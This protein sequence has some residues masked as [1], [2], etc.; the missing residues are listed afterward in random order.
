MQK[1]TSA[2]VLE[3]KNDV[4]ADIFNHLLFAD[5]E[6]LKINPD[7]LED[8]PTESF[9]TDLDGN[10]RNLFR[11]I[12]KKYLSEQQLVL[13]SLGLENEASV[14]RP[15]PI[16]VM[17]YAYTHYKKQ[18]DEYKQNKKSLLKLRKAAQTKAEIDFVENALAEL[19]EFKL[20]P[21]LTLVLC[22]DDKEWEQPR[23]LSGLADG[24][25]YT[26]YMQDY[27]ITV[28]NMKHLPQDIRNQ[29]TS[30]F[31]Y[32]ANVLCEGKILDEDKA[33]ELTYP[34]E[35]LDML[36]AY[37]ND[38]RYKEIR[39]R[40]QVKNMEGVRISMGDFLDEL[41]RNK[42]IEDAKI[43][44]KKG[45]LKDFIIEVLSESLKISITEAT[46][47]FNNEVKKAV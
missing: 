10:T 44:E 22:F 15:M 1:D 3:S 9:Y 32:I 16:R 33:K 25:P 2:K 34:M 7:F 46:E 6:E 11:D 35:T 8:E 12:L 13:V 37:T 45:A 18:L 39:K 30:D 5:N 27:G 20:V 36:I 43:L 19:G 47:V 26:K 42:A 41:E 14:E 31:R 38:K 40:I 24:N 28:I 4:F 17:G 23:T 29:F 21:T